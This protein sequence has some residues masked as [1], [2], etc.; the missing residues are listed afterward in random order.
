MIQ[1]LRFATCKINLT[2]TMPFKTNNLSRNITLIISAEDGDD[3]EDELKNFAS[4][5]A[6]MGGD[7]HP[8][9]RKVNVSFTSLLIPLG[10][11]ITLFFPGSL[12]AQG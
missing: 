6:T 10:H 1:A 3:W 2:K 12:E 8:N 4:R 9:F 5:V 11:F 7:T